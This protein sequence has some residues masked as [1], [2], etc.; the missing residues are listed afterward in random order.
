MQQVEFWMKRYPT[1]NATGLGLVDGGLR[2][3][4]EMFIKTLKQS[5]DELA[6]EQ[7]S[8][9]PLAVRWFSAAR[10]GKIKSLNRRHNS[11]E[12][13]GVVGSSIGVDI[14]NG[15]LILAALMSGFKISHD[16][17]PY[18]NMSEKSLSDLL[19]KR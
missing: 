10:V 7:G 4:K 9:L 14:S 6:A 5:R 3:S 2:L 15:V 18:F 19:N 8:V 12:L 1:L 13:R 17:F 16:H 11:E